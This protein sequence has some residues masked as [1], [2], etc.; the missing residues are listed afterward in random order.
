MNTSTPA[1]NLDAL[2]LDQLDTAS[3]GSFWSGL[4]HIAHNVAN[5]AKVAVQD[6]VNGGTIGG[7]GGAIAGSPAGV[8]GMGVGAAIGGAGGGIVGLSYGI[9]HEVSKYVK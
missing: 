9:A 7:V 5:S 6:M 2:T 8:P 3:G 4:T 1:T